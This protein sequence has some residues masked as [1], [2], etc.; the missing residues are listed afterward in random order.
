VP[1]TR[2]REKSRSLESIIKEVE[3]LVKNGYKLIT[4]LGQNVNSYQDEIDGEK[5]GFPVLLNRLCEIE[6]DFWLTFLTSHPKDFS[7]EL[8]DTMKDCDKICNYLNLPVQSGSN[9][10][11]QKMNRN[12]TWRD[13]I[14][15]IAY[16][17][18]KL[19]DISLSTDIIVGFPGETEED[20][21]DTYNLVK[22]IGFD[23]AY[24]SPY[25]PREG[26]ASAKLDDNV[27]RDEKKRRKK[28]V[29][30]TVTE[31]KKERNEE[32]IG[33][34][35]KILV[36]GEERG[37]TFELRDVILKGKG[38]EVN[39]FNKGKII[40]AHAGGLVSRKV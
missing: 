4:L 1:F 24:V 34:K 13:Y 16:L 20:F 19:P 7:P 38:W 25:S 37:K 26:S 6:G 29:S 39:E 15:K 2:G 40:D 27:T 23:M 9:R 30:D 12:Y 22:K 8:V 28:K 5:V 17:R 3:E 18:E 32:Q 10:I 11:L 35:V 14:E 31:F 33:Q 21:L 36:V